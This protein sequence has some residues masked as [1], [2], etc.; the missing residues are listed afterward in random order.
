M[1]ARTSRRACAGFTL[2][3][4]MCTLAVAGVLSSMAYPS[5]QNVVHK[6]RRSDAHV[7]LL[8][9]QMAQERF[10]ADNPRYGSLAD[11][12]FAA[13]SP[14][15]HYTLEVASNDAHGFELRASAQGA[16][17]ADTTCRHLSLEVTGHNV[18]RASGPDTRFAND[19]AANRHCWG[20]L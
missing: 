3:E 2:I 5:Y 12:R 4:L 10:R 17:L 14:L 8:Q 13:R 18:T 16:Q 1:A 6:T 7:A 9:L 19:A 15:R 11:L 20:G